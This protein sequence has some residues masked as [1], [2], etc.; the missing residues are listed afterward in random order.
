SSGTIRANGGGSTTETLRANAGLVAGNATN[1]SGD[2][3]VGGDV[4]GSVVI[5]GTL[6]VPASAT[7]ASGVQAGAIVHESVTVT[8]PCDC[9]TAASVD[10]AGAIASART[11]NDDGAIGLAATALT[12]NVSLPDGRF[13]VT[14][15][16]TASGNAIAIAV[17][18]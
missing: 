18:G 17:H 5:G 4:S 9:A 7:G 8:P 3:F 2:A 1:V 14:S 12:S 11:S 16:S 13:Y 6:H 10:V 15:L